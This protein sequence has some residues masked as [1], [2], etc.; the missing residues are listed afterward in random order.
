M[1]TYEGVNVSIHIFLASALVWG[2]W[3]A[4]RPGRLTPGKEPQVPILL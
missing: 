4:S 2:E 1:K 3:L